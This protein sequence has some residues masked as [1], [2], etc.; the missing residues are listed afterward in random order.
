MSLC[1]ALCV[2]LEALKQ[3]FAQKTEMIFLYLMTNE[4]KE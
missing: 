2:T 3:S 1:H 4:F